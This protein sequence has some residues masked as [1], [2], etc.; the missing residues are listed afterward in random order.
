MFKL[1]T[2]NTL[3]A[4]IDIQ[5]KLVPVMKQ[6][7]ISKTKENVKK[8]INGFNILDLPVVATQ[9]YTKGLGSTI[10]ELSELINNDAIEKLTFSCCGEPAFL[11]FLK[12]LN[13]K[14]VVITGMETHICVLQTVID[15][16]EKD[17]NVFVVKDAVVS[18]E[19]MN[20]ETGVEYM[21]DAGA[22]IT[23]TETV[24]FQLLKKSGT[25][26]FKQISKLVK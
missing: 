1:S 17:Y 3:L 4:V 20:W 13:I 11:D 14:N 26:E 25:P 15:L 6:K 7:I 22:V 5:E 8:L 2:E 9:Q 21:R 18:R 19:K 10:S 24:L 23:I 12:K 16:L